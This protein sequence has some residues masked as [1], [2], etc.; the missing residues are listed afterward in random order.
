MSTLPVAE[1]RAFD[2]RVT[3]LVRAVD[4]DTFDLTVTKRIDFGFR[5]VEEKSWSARFRLL[6]IDAPE[7]NTAGGT[8]A[9][10]YA[11]EWITAAIRDDVLRGQ[12]FKTDNFG[13]WLIDLYRVDNAEHLHARMIAD[14][15]GIPYRG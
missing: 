9:T 11:R 1:A 13:R 8:A 10:T 6:G 7:T 3:S 15:N 2:Y 5:L 14:G 12:T 4:G